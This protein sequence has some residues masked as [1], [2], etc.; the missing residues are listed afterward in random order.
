MGVCDEKNLYKPFRSK[1]KNKKY[2]VCVRKDGKIK[3]IH[4]GDSRYRHNYS[5]KA[6]KSY[7]ARSAG[8]KGAND[9][10]TP[11]YWARTFLWDA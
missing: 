4:F 3:L 6:R 7:L 2:S 11:N 5:K 9:K 10:N 1:A 8:I